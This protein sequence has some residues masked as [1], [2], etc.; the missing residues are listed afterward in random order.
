MAELLNWVNHNQGVAAWVQAI[1]SIVAIVAGILIVQ[2]QNRSARKTAL[3]E[4]PRVSWR[5]I[6]LS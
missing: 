4:S 1:G 5:P 2:W 3:D 6:G